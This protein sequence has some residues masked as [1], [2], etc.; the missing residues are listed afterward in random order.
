VQ[1]WE[2]FLKAQQ[3]EFGEKAVDHW[4]RTLKVLRFDAC[5]LFLEAEDSFQA[6]WFEEHIREKA[7]TQFVNNNNR[8]IKI[9]LSV[10]EDSSTQTKKKKFVKK[11]PDPTL[12]LEPDPLN[13]D[14]THER[15]VVGP[16]N[17]IAHKILCEL[18]EGGS[19]FNPIYIYGQGGTGKT[20][21]LMAIAHLL[22]QKNLK[23]F[24]V[25][26]ETFTDHVVRAIRSGAMQEFRRIYRNA[27]VLIVD[28]IH[29]LAR[30]AATQEEF[31]HTFNTLHTAG[32]QI[33]LS[34][35]CAPQFLQEIEARL[36]S[37]FEWGIT[38]P[39]EKLS[40]DELRQVIE[41]RCHALDFPLE[42]PVIDFLLKTFHANVKSLH[43][44]LEALVLRSH[45]RPQV[46]D[47]GSITPLLSDLIDLENQNALSPEKIVRAVAELF[48][49][50]SDD[51]L[52]KAQSH[53]CTLPRQIA[54][55]LCRKELQIPFL[56]IG[57]VF[58]R[59]HSTVMSSVKQVQT[60][61]EAQD[62][63]T[64]SS[65]AEILRKLT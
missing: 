1:A 56:R 65:V 32:K 63:D 52:G 62:P 13:P 24:F 15:F 61:L 48:G 11:T 57:K 60:K 14:S 46:I 12:K 17:A 50:R 19:P 9:H 4:L 47:L 34:S 45:M 33:V 42:K 18:S 38:I 35:Q 49:I 37:R 54:M 6:N 41:N 27:D 39:L 51:I 53:D 21:L 64:C 40:P 44:A 30:R 25:N 16:S 10:L 20:H 59:D 58:D 22:Q 5:N 29:L 55:F 43:R 7:S 36:I 8:P 28:D 2:E 26:A 31:F 23:V 3:A